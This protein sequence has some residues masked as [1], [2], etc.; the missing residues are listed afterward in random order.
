[1]FQNARL[2]LTA[3]Y[4]LIIM[5]ISLVFSTVIY[6]VLLNEVTRF[7][8]AQRFRIER[9]IGPIPIPL[10]VDPDPDLIIEA[11]HRILLFLILVNSGILISSGVL[12][13]ILAGRTLEPI[14]DM[15][16]EQNRFIS[17][18]SHELKTP[19]TSLKT[20]MEVYLRGK[21]GLKNAHTL[22]NESISEVDKLQTLSESLLILARHGVPENQLSITKVS[23][24]EVIGEAIR[25]IKPLALKKHI[26][27][28][29]SGL[30]AEI[31][32]DSSALV[33]L[34]V[35]LLDNAV[36][37]SSAKSP[38]II[39]SKRNDGSV[40]ITVSDKGPG[41]SAVDLPHIFDR[42]Y[43]ADSSRSR[44]GPGGYGLGLSIAKQIIA[45]HHGTITVVSRPGSGSAF[46]IRLPLRRPHT[47]KFQ[48]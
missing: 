14:S 18:A 38:V 30:D 41:I 44:P 2:K 9:R 27:V 7:A 16:D 12:G 3:W 29:K 23:L 13:Y 5:S 15:V 11:R 45:S 22:I 8:Q 43:R 26:P 21:P 17:D 25:K 10:I 6:R 40:L 28:N 31:E 37:Y 24:R 36:K 33:N 20:A 42:F 35:I 34:L 39:S 1:M 48:H 4:L 47:V 46:T 19:L 32:A